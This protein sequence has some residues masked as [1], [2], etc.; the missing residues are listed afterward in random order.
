M[1]RAAFVVPGP[2]GG[3]LELRETEVPQVTPGGVLVR[4]RASGLNRGEVLYKHAAL[5]GAPYVGGVEFAGEI[6]ELGDGVTG[7]TIGQRVMGH[8]AATQADY[9]VVEQRALMPVPPN[10]GWAEAAAFPNV[11]VTAHDAVVRAGSFTAGESVIINA[12]GSGIGIAS[13]QIARVLGAQTVIGTSRNRDKLERVKPLGLTHAVATP[14]E[15]LAPAVKAATAGRGV[16]LVIDS[17][18]GSALPET[19]KVMAMNGRLVNVGRMGGRTAELDMER[20]SFFGLRVIGVSFRARTR[21]QTLDC[22]QACA[23][24][25]LPHLASGGI[26]V[27]IEKT[28]RLEDTAAAHDF[29]EQDTHVGKIVL[30]FD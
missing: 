20:L 28:F 10:L 4:V 15:P 24:D 25:L 3:R 16:D 30:T 26:R 11:F 19:L 7:F 6:S 8:G 17:V 2:A 18:G 1:M 29:A 9:V 14:D 23:R 21:E 22:I 12:A 13:V 27:P 5:K